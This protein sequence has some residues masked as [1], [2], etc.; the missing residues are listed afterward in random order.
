MT[1]INNIGQLV[2]LVKSGKLTNA[3]LHKIVLETMSLF[4]SEDEHNLPR[5]VLADMLEK[6][7]DKYFTIGANIVP[8]FL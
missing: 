1:Q 4:L 7:Y 2:E 8:L 6:H 5:E 3:E